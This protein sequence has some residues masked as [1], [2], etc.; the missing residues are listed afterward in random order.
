[1]AVVHPDQARMTEELR[2]RATEAG[3]SQDT[4]NKQRL[5]KRGL[6]ERAGDAAS[7]VASVPVRAFTRGQYGAGDVL[8][9]VSPIAGSAIARSERDFVD[10]NPGLMW[11]LGAAGEVAAGIPALNTLGRAAP[12]PGQVASPRTHLAAERAANATEDLGAAQRLNVHVPGFAFNEGPVASVA[13]QLSETPIIGTPVRRAMEG[14]IVDTARAA[15]NVA[16]R[17]GDIRTPQQTGAAVEQGL[18]RFRDARPADVLDTAARN[19]PDADI[20]AVASAPARDTSLRSKQAVLYERAWRQIPEE[21]RGGA[22]VQGHTRVMAAPAATRAV[23][24]DIMTRNQRMTVAGSVP[25][26][27][28][29]PVRGGLLGSMLEAINNPRWTANLQTLRD[30]RSELR[31]LA[32]GMSDTERNVLRHSDIERLQVGLTQDMIALLQRNADGY[33]RA[34]NVG[35]AQQF[36]RS[37]HQ[38]RQADRYTA[39]SM[40]RLEGIERLFNAPNAEALARN[41][42]QAALNQGRG[43]IDA[44]RTLRRTLRQDEMSALASGLIRELG[45]PVG[46]ARGIAQEANFSVQSFLTRWRNMSPEARDIL[47]DGPHRA[48]LD[49]LVRV[50]SR[51]ANVEALANTSRTGTNSLNLGGLLATGGA[52]ATGAVDTV[53][54]GL[55]MA[56]SGL[57]AS[58]LMSRPEYARWMTAYLRMRASQRRKT[59]GQSPR[60]AEHVRGLLAMAANDDALRPVAEA[61]ARENGVG[62]GRNVR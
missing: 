26:N 43:N 19:L 12:R 52:I 45:V 30:M 51:L 13:K 6:M 9:A 22:A 25:E 14:A 18:T 5:A 11:T 8:G 2:M 10:A 58:I 33:R 46:S 17:Y 20:R 49:D 34:G 40:Q 42:T 47:F 31:R 44:L 29:M 4:I 50:A 15:D 35:L 61:I 1:M 41:I 57:A 21:M 56:G 27:D 36:E 59:D 7:F 48:A 23:L 3:P 37:I 38:F 24:N 32:S 39:L 55:G 28:L 62:N 16:G 60:I 53:T 54:A